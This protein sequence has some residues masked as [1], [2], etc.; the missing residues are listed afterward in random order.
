MTLLA[1]ATAS[2]AGSLHCAAMCGGFSVIAGNACPA[3]RARGQ[4]AYAVGRLLAY[5]ALGLIAGGLGALFEV[6]PRL[7]R[8]LGIAVGAGL[9]AMALPRIFGSGRP[10]SAPLIRIGRGPSWAKGLRAQ[11]APVYRARGTTGS[12][13]MGAASAVLPCG[14][15]WAYVAVAAAAG[16]VLEG[17]AVMG[18]FW[19]GTVPALATVGWVGGR[20]SGTL[21]R[22]APRLAAVALLGLG[23]MTLAG[24]V[25]PTFT[26]DPPP[27][28]GAPCH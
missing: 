8:G 13:V 10:A 20:L 24:K 7:H 22:H 28:Q 1:I 16:G 27:A 9:V 25:G 26:A 18:A 21:G 19:V 4:V 11:L 23:L 3:A 15:L 12:L 17:A 2:L 5:L 14:W 6:D